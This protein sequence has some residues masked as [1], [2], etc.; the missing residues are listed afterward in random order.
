MGAAGMT[1]GSVARQCIET[2][3]QPLYAERTEVRA[4]L[5]AR[6]EE[7]E[8]R[9]RDDLIGLPDL[10][11]SVDDVLE[12]IDVVVVDEP[13]DLLEGVSA[14]Y[15]DKD[16]IGTVSFLDL[17]DR[18]GFTLTQRSPR[19]PEP[20]Q[21]ILAA[22]GIEIEVFTTGGRHEGR[23][24]VLRCCRRNWGRHARRRIRAPVTATCSDDEDHG[25]RQRDQRSGRS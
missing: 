1:V 14:S 6:I 22:Q 8:G 13:V 19:R 7:D 3:R 12:R 23:V 17:C 21:H 25:T 16:D 4:G 15:A 20:Q 11:S 10:T 2:L 9:L 5:A 18:R 24:D